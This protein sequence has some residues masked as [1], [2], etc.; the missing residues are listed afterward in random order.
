MAEM[1]QCCP[2]VD[3]RHTPDCKICADGH[4]FEQT[5]EEVNE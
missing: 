5:D 2:H 1:G 3:V 4:L